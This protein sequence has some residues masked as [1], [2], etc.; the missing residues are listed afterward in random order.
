MDCALK[1]V[2]GEVDFGVFNAEEALV[3]SRFINEDVSVIGEVRHRARLTGES[4]V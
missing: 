3:A 1:L 4:N 2:S